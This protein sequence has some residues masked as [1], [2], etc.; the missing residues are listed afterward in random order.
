MVNGVLRYGLVAAL[1]VRI[2][3]AGVAAI[4]ASA[5]S[6]QF[7]YEENRSNFR[8]SWREF[9]S[10]M[11]QIRSMRRTQLSKAPASVPSTAVKTPW[12]TKGRLM[13]FLV[14]TAFWLSV[15]IVLLPTPDSMKAPESK[16]GATQ[17]ISAATAAVSD[18]RGFC[19]RQPEACEVGSNALTFG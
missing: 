19:T 6:H 8:K 10:N 18:A 13:M 4:P 12:K 17:A 7:V 11:D 14:R 15:A 2:G 1:Q 16:V 9:V 3:N 5:R